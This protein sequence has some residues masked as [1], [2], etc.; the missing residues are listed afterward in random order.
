MSTLCIVWLPFYKIPE[1]YFFGKTDSVFGVLVMKINHKAKSRYK[2]GGG[3]VKVYLEFDS[4]YV[5]GS[6]A[7]I[8]VIINMYVLLIKQTD[9]PIKIK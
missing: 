7:K 6:K 1:V 2:M 3:S 9:R 4:E 8:K 5:C